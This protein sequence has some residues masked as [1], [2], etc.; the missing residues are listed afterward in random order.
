MFLEDLLLSRIYTKK[1]YHVGHPL[2][3]KGRAPA[4]HPILTS[5]PRFLL[6]NQVRCVSSFSKGVQVC[7]SIAYLVC[8]FVHPVNILV[9]FVFVVNENERQ[10]KNKRDERG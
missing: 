6:L 10:K 5:P 9:P 1:K 8:P 2:M 7:V 3:K 4:L